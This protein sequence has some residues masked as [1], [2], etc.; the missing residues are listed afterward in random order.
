MGNRIDNLKGTV[1]KVQTKYAMGYKTEGYIG[2]KLFPRMSVD[3]QLDEAKIP[4]FGQEHLRLY[5]DSRAPGSEI[6]TYRPDDLTFVSYKLEE[7]SLAFTYDVEE[8]IAA[9][10]LFDMKRMYTNKGLMAQDLAVEAAIS[11]AAQ[12]AATYGANTAAL[13]GNNCWSSDVSAHADSTPYIDIETG[14]AAIYAACGKKPN[15]MILGESS[16][17]A[18]RNH[19]H[20]IEKI[21]YSQK[22]VVTED[23]ISDFISTK[24]N[25]IDVYVG[26]AQYLAGTTWTALWSDNVVLAYVPP[27]MSLE[28]SYYTPS[29]AKLLMRSDMP[30]VLSYTVGDSGLVKG[31]ATR[32]KYQPKIT[33]ATAGYLITNTVT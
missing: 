4:I 30:Q 3:P 1:D 18:L 21:K 23:L 6:K 11:D 8:V 26:A 33:M 15:V 19:P 5:E 25:K 12:T 32:A 7:H 29:F 17:N 9:K 14:I 13:T 2:E 20:S 27:N 24:T 28:Q 16:F 10:A 31:I 22:A